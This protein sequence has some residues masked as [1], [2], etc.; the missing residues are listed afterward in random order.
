MLAFN[1]S[2]PSSPFEVCDEGVIGAEVYGSLENR[3]TFD[4]AVVE[5]RVSSAFI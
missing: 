4:P 3:G 1:P 2:W 5:A